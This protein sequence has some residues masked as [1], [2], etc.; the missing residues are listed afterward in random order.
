MAAGL[1]Q[2][3]LAARSGLSVRAI[4]EM[5]R[6]RSARPYQRSVR[7]LAQ[8]LS[9][10]DAQH[11]ELSVLARSGTDGTDVAAVT[12]LGQRE[13]PNAVPRQL[14]A[15]VSC[16]TGRD[17]ELAALTGLLDGQPGVRTPALVISAIGGT[18]GVGK[19]ALAV[20]WAHMVAR[21]FPDGQL[22]VNLRG[23]D[24][25]EPVT[26]AEALAGFL[27]TLG[28]PGT[29]IPDDLEDRVRLYRSRL[30]D[31]QVLV[32]LDNAR[33]PDQVRPLLPGDA[34]CVAVVTSRDTLAGLVITDGARRLDL[35]VLPLADAVA[36]LRSLIGPR[37]D[38]DSEA[39]A[40]LAGLCARLP[41]ALRI[42]AEL[43]AVRGQVPLPDLV[44]ELAA[45][46][47]DGLDAGEDRADVR[48]VFSWSLR[49]LD[50]SAAAAFTLTGLHP[51]EDLD[52]H[53]AAALIGTT[54]DQAR[55]L[56]GQLQRASLLQAVGP[57]RYAMHD[58]LRAY[59]A[60]RAAEREPETERRSA[61]QRLF[62]YYLAA[63]AAAMDILYPAEA[64]R[65][66]RIQ[67]S[68]VAAPPMHGDADARAWLDS[69]RANL[70]A[71][72][73]HCVAQRWPRYVTDLAATLFRYLISG[74]HLPEAHAIY[75]NALDAARLSGDLA[76]EAETLNGLGGIAVMKGQGRNAAGHYQAALERYRLCGDRA[77]EARALHNLGITDKESHDY[78]SAACYYRQAIAAFEDAGDG[79]GAAR[80]LAYLAAAET[81]LGSYEE[82]AEHLRRALPVLQEAKDPTGEADALGR[83]G[84]LNLR[85]GQLDEAAA[86]FEQA[87]AIYRS[88]DHP[89]GVAA[90]LCNLGEVSVRQHQYRQAIGSLRQALGLYRESGNQYGQSVTLRTLAKALEG[91]GQTT[92]ARVE[93][94]T[95]LRLAAETRN[96][97]QQAAVHGDLAESH[98]RAGEDDQARHHWQQALALYTQ[99]RATEAEQVR[100]QLA[101]MASG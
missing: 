79:L 95:A 57:G 100:S 62:D 81:E 92:A 21:R 77:G 93:L 22:Y 56:L 74:S 70:A 17:A 82:A 42:A 66:P 73:A 50:Q 13:L 35:D 55:R 69:E 67:A 83:I 89:G 84:M 3:E 41:L 76:A 28:V 86:F 44:A 99:L 61:L 97:Y 11:S 36:L 7:L 49:Q 75:C 64:H 90:G 72:S 45:G 54:A 101:A 46:R 4:R 19:T 27:R 78:R 98:H 65:R 91:A 2:E 14:P 26:A 23:Y 18:A 60:E 6:G 71:V 15:A 52:V 40:E 31:R 58:L 88:L 59:A 94:Q 30:A 87:L 9:L 53:A 39:A 63:A 34:G 12:R 33:D 43:A 10:T 29:D 25:G 32:L 68:A 5:E 8:A 38:Q 1:T 37:A 48:A 80:A 16:F 24:T 47:L 20:Q 96:T 85:C 51:G